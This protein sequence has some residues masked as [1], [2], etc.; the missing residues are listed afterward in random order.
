[1]SSFGVG[2]HGGGLPPSYVSSGRCAASPFTFAA[3]QAT[4]LLVSRKPTL[5]WRGVWAG[6]AA[7]VKE[8]SRAAARGTRSGQVRPCPATPPNSTQR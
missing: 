3:G 7:Q 2:A 8:E 4:T 1:M 5:R 6:L